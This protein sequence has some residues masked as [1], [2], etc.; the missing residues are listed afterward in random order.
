MN[1]FSF[2]LYKEAMRQ[3]RTIGLVL[4]VLSGIIASFLPVVYLVQ[5]RNEPASTVL[6]INVNEMVSGLSIIAIVVPIALIVKLFGFLFK[7]SSSDFYHALPYTRQ[8]IYITHFL[9]VLTWCLIVLAV[10]VGL[11]AFFYGINSHIEY[12]AVFVL[13]NFVVALVMMLFIAG[14]MLVAASVTGRSLI[15]I[16]LAGF[17]VFLPRALILLALSVIE[18]NTLMI[19]INYIPFFSIKYSIPMIM[20]VGS[21]FDY[22]GY[23]NAFSYLPGILTSLTVAVIYLILGGVLFSFRRSETAENAA[24]NRKVQTVIRIV[25]SMVFFCFGV[26]CIFVYGFGYEA[27]IA[28]LI[29]LA[30]YLLYELITTKK[31]KNVLKSLPGLAIVAVLCVVYGLTIKLS[32][33]SVLNNVPGAYDIESVQIVSGSNYYWL[34]D[35]DYNDLLKNNITFQDN[36]INNIVAKAFSDTAQKVKNGELSRYDYYTSISVEMRIN[37]KNGGSKVRILYL[38]DEEYAK[39]QTA[40]M[41]Q[42]EYYEASYA[43][44]DEAMLIEFS[45]EEYNQKI[46]KQFQAEYNALTDE[47]KSRVLGESPYV[48]YDSADELTEYAS[49]DSDA[50]ASEDNAYVAL[51]VYGYYGTQQFSKYYYCFNSLMPK[52]VA[53]YNEY[54]YREKCESMMNIINMYEDSSVS[55]GEINLYLY[56]TI[57]VGDY[58]TEGFDLYIY[59]EG[60]EI[61]NGSINGAWTKVEDSEE[62]DKDYWYDME[63]GYY[64][65][66]AEETKVLADMFLSAIDYTQQ[67]ESGKLSATVNFGYYEQTGFNWESDYIS[68]DLNIKEAEYAELAE[69]LT[70]RYSD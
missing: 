6:F 35:V 12:K 28:F 54:S 5:Y 33:D 64:E 9:A 2:R 49:V 15:S 68:I 38:S 61:I 58:V 65:L 17:I 55:S 48:E 53:L 27:I 1:Y 51:S 8:C 37:S 45:N 31:L 52:T 44:P 30:V 41:K 21:M 11:P 62:K 70:E 16:E 67:A 32:S 29:G 57:R 3:S 23:L 22:T 10:L 69:L 46:W 39:L 60:N 7:R 34:E 14:A 42:K 56:E 36:E 19:D 63:Y 47:Q 66:S 20:I 40:F 4:T 18:N 43:I 13:Y 25:F 24:P 26:C 50:S 59:Y